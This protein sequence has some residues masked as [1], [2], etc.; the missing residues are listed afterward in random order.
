MASL[1]Q[2]PLN[3]EDFPPPIPP[4]IPAQNFSDEDILLLAKL[5]ENK[6]PQQSGRDTLKSYQDGIT[7]PPFPTK[8]KLQIGVS[9]HCHACAKYQ[10][11]TAIELLSNT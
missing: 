11:A 10:Y 5:S 8:T 7:M 1:P 3:T 4:P 9:S 6:E 2:N